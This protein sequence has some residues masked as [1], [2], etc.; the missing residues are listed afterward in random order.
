MPA[1]SYASHADSCGKAIREYGD[2]LVVAEFERDNA[3]Q[4]PGLYGVSG[5]KGVTAAPEAE[6]CVFCFGPRALSNGFKNVNRNF[7]VRQRFNSN[8]GCIASSRIVV[9]FKSLH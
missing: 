6:V 2:E 9:G 1:A 7:I 5:W 3:C 8:A 4:S